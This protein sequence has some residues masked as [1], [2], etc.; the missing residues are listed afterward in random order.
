MEAILN[1]LVISEEK[2]LESIA[3][4]ERNLED[5]YNSSIP[6]RKKI[7]TPQLFLLHFRFFGIKKAKQFILLHESE[8]MISNLKMLDETPVRLIMKIPLLYLKSIDSLTY[9]TDYQSDTSFI[10]FARSLGTILEERHIKTG[11]F[12]HIKHLCTNAGVVYDTNCFT[13]QIFVAPSLKPLKN[14]PVRND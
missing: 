12:D 6:K 10:D 2:A 7:K 11:N 4:Q 9:E 1:D 3:P 5:V 13:E 8:K 14:A